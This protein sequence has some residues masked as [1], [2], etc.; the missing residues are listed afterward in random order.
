MYY[1]YLFQTFWCYK[2]RHTNLNILT[3]FC[4]S[5]V[6]VVVVIIIN[7]LYTNLVLVMK[8]LVV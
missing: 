4:N 6:V 7:A 8:L 3:S 2:T 5:S 1:F